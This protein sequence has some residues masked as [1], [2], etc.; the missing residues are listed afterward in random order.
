MKPDPFQDV[1]METARELVY[2]SA[3]SL[4][5]MEVEKEQLTAARLAKEAELDG[6]IEASE[7]LG[8]KIEAA[9]ERFRKAVENAINLGME[10]V[11][12]QNGRG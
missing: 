8:K 6:L 7:V 9:E 5:R 4:A 1:D 11:R 2:L 3:L 12:N 10:I